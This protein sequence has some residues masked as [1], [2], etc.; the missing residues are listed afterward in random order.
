METEELREDCKCLQRRTR[1][2]QV[3]YDQ[4]SDCNLLL[5]NN[6]EQS[7]N[8]CTNHRL[9]YSDAAGACTYLLVI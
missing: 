8:V 6:F 2:G 9:L 1:N 4:T 5:N 3:Q 7:Q